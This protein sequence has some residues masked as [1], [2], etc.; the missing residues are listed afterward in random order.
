MGVAGASLTAFTAL[1]ALAAQPTA[2]APAV[3]RSVMVPLQLAGMP[4]GALSGL[5][6]VNAPATRETNTDVVSTFTGTGHCTLN[7][8]FGDGSLKKLDG[9]LSSS[10][11]T[12]THSYGGM[13]SFDAFKDF[14]ASVTPGG[15]GKISIGMKPGTITPPTVVPTIGAMSLPGGITAVTGSATALTVMGTGNCTHH[16]SY[17]NL[18]AQGKTILKPYPMLLKN[19]TP[20]SP[21]LM[22]MVLVQATPA[23]VYKWTASGVDGCTGVADAVLTVQ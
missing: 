23:G 22:N 11:F 7:L 3:A 19:S 9:E 16:L 4:P 15:N 12:H 6:A 5:K 1:T 20:Q 2:S 14:N 10:S 13:S 18:D 8:D 21:F 17:V